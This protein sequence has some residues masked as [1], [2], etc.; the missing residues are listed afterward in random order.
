[1]KYTRVLTRSLALAE[2][3]VTCS[4]GSGGYSDVGVLAGSIRPL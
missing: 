3:L 4:A 2:D 1:M